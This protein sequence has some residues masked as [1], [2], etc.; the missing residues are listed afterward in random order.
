[1][2]GTQLPVDPCFVRN[3]W[4]EFVYVPAR[5][6]RVPGLSTLSLLI[7]RREAERFQVDVRFVCSI[8]VICKL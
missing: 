7:P 3:Q 1:M 6:P 2:F 5:I 4:S 8:S